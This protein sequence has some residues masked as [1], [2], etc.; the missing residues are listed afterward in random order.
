M[1][2][3][4]ETSYKY[5]YL[6]NKYPDQKEFYSEYTEGGYLDKSYVKL[7]G[8]KKQFLEYDPS[9]QGSYA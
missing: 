5:R 1:E 3:V 4:S 2:K 9:H 8:E 7:Y 6:K